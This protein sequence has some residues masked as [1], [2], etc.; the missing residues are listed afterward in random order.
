MGGNEGLKWIASGAS[1]PTGNWTWGDAL[2]WEDPKSYNPMGSKSRSTTW[3]KTWPEGEASKMGSEV[4][5]TIEIGATMV[6]GKEISQSKLPQGEVRPPLGSC[7]LGMRCTREGQSSILRGKEGGC[8][9]HS[10]AQCIWL[11][12][13]GDVIKCYLEVGSSLRT[14]TK[15]SI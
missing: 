2:V 15:L 11:G 13:G 8:S 7:F 14:T 1:R 10:W 12:N 6:K 4:A 9:S 5:C 3:G